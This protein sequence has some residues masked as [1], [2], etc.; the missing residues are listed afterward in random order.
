VEVQNEAGKPLAGY[1]LAE[2]NELIGDEI[3][4]GATWESGS[5]L[6]RFAG[7][8]IRLRFVMKDADIYSVGFR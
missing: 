8:P 5:D 7:Q 1:G 2:A 3:E 6:S 4:R